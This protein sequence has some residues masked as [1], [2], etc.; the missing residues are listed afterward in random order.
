[1]DWKIL[2]TVF[3]SVFIAELGLH[4]PIFPQWLEK[5]CPWCEKNTS[6]SRLG[7]RPSKRKP[8]WYQFTR[9]IA[10]CPYCAKPVK[11]G[12]QGQAWVLLV[13]PALFAPLVELLFN[14]P[15]RAPLLSTPWFFILLALAVV[16]LVAA[17]VS[18]RLEKSDE[19]L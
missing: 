11:P 19:Q 14:Q 15:V 9:N 7:Q 2:A 16:G 17:A 3:V 10:V 1:M 5:T 8:K 4:M 13:A 6:F 12:K 18:A